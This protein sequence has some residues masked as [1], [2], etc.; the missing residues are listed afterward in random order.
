MACGEDRLRALQGRDHAVGAIELAPGWLAVDMRSDE[1]RRQVRL[2]TA[3][4]QE[5]VGSRVG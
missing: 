4:P 1:N 2:A 5:E 3:K